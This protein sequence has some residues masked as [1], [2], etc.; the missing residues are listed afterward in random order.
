MFPTLDIKTI[1]F[2]AEPRET[3]GI[4]APESLRSSATIDIRKLFRD[5][6]L[7]AFFAI[8][9]SAIAVAELPQARLYWVYPPGGKQGTVTE[10]TIGGNDLDEVNR[11][12]F[13]HP[14][15][16]AVPKVS[17][18]RA[19]EK[20][21]R[22][23]P[24]QFVVSIATDVPPGIYEARA[25]GH[26]GLS[27]SRMFEVN[28]LP[29]IV[30]QG[31]NHALERALPIAV[32]SVVNARSDPDNF[33]VF[34]F[35]AKQGE[36]VIIGCA[37]RRLDSRMMPVIE[38]L[39]TTGKQLGFGQGTHR[40]EPSIDFTAPTDG[41]YRI[42]ISD[43]VYR[44]GD[45]FFYRLELS[46][47]PHIDFVFPPSGMRG[48]TNRFT[49]Y[50]H[51]LPGGTP[52]P[53]TSM[54]AARGMEAKLEQLEVEVHIPSEA[55]CLGLS[56][57][58]HLK[59]P[60]QATVDG[61]V[62]RLSSPAG[63]SNP[64][65]ISHAK[66][67][68]VIEQE[69][70]DDPAKSHLLSLPCEIAGQ[71]FP[72]RDADWF[73]FEA[74]K[75]QTYVI[76]LFS[77]RLT[78]PTDPTIVVQQVSADAEG[79]ETVRVI[80]EQ[81]DRTTNFVNS[82]FDAPSHD[83]TIMFTADA[84]GLHRVLVRDLYS[85]SNSHPSNIYRMTIGA[86]QPDFQLV[87]TSR[88]LIEVNP[89]RVISGSPT[90]WQGGAQPMTVQA[91]RSGGFDGPITLTVEGLP[92]GL[93][94]A[95][96]VIGPKQQQ[97]SLVASATV[98]AAPWSGS[99]KVV[100]TAKLDGQDVRREALAGSVVWDQNS[101]VEMTFVRIAQ[102]AT[103]AVIPE[104]APVTLTML[105]DKT[106]E[107]A[108]AG[109]LTIPLKIER[110]IEIK[111][112]PKLE[113]R[114]MPPE[115]KVAPIT[116]DAQAN[117]AKVEITVEPNTPPGDY[118]LYFVLQARGGYQRNP[119][120]VARAEEDKKKFAELVMQLTEAAKTAEA[121][122]VGAEKKVSDLAAVGD[123]AET[124]EARKVA[125]EAKAKVIELA[126]VSLDTLKAA[127]EEQKVVDKRAV[128]LAEAA[129]P[130][131]IET[132]TASRTVS[133]NVAEVPV[134]LT[135]ISPVTAIKSGEQ[136][137]IAIT[138][139]RLFGFAGP[140]DLET[141]LP[142]GVAGISIDK[143]QISPEQPEGKLIVKAAADSTPGTHV[144]KVRA[145]LN[146]NGPSLQVERTVEVK[147]EPAATK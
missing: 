135:I 11:L 60:I 52:A 118:S 54:Q 123:N 46:T 13:T 130:K 56:P 14:G 17:P 129:K 92:T 33:D 2:S 85:G 101:R 111:G 134:K 6:S 36:R 19:F 99:V 96:V 35:D 59:E 71:F 143:I 79:K 103:L 62:Y 122:R 84:D 39:D 109:K 146:F 116:L 18:L 106:W 31:D 55:T 77:E 137:D 97:V 1:N 64:V 12:V 86:P 141:T 89:A 51:H 108:R 87:A 100:G 102:E 115:I 126:K 21:P 90:L 42:K 8:T 112:N 105:E 63:P 41:A 44:G 120:A 114:G 15:I 124:T 53:L 72:H 4:E 113:A 81:D 30:E 107:T 69:P 131:E 133:I 58:N 49:L 136:G 78:L 10:V 26:Y 65:F 125:E 83:A 140:I 139:E 67:P 25:S 75:G 45:E 117:D 20:E 138:A 70:N 9:S 50:G 127:L 27:T 128:D 61:Y 57:S 22:A 104:L 3:Y 48:A 98:D 43:S 37:T 32:N 144:I 119:A 91:Y 66:A 94:V 121:D 145:R 29:E 147:I 74:Q 40:R 23:V 24:N 76:D 132:F 5:W 88:A 28:D 110:R 38:I 142:S 68:V 82:P 34:Q 93:S 95:P 80:Q 7:A 16:T 73:S 47:R